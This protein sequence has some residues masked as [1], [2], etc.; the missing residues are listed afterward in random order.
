MNTPIEILAQARRLA[1][2]AKS[3]EARGLNVLADQM[4][5]D[6]DEKIAQ[7]RAYRALNS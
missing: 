7:F 1:L 2:A 6:A 3:F 5:A 4:L